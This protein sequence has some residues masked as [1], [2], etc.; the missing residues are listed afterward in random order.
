[1]ALVEESEEVEFHSSRLANQKEPRILRAPF[2]P[3]LAV[4]MGAQRCWT[5]NNML[6]LELVTLQLPFF[7]RWRSTRL[8]Q[9]I[10]RI[11][12]FCYSA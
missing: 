9:N 3:F 12:A 8:Q 1:M 10:R 6:E 4:S 11:D 2:V 7:G 5:G